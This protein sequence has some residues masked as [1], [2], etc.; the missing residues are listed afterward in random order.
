MQN[1]GVRPA[2]PS[3]LT[4]RVKVCRE[5]GSADV[6]G[7]G[8]ARLVPA[9]EAAG[10]VG[11]HRKKGPL[12]A[13]FERNRFKYKSL[14]SWA[15]NIAMGCNHACRFCSAGSFME[16]AV[17]WWRLCAPPARCDRRRACPR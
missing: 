4:F 17:A 8:L 13:Y 1:L 16:Q 5:W 7:D 14:S 11:R 10:S 3:E 9:A 12:H 2:M 6:S 15:Y